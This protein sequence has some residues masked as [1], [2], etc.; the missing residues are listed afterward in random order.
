MATATA[1]PSTVRKNSYAK[2]RRLRAEG[3]TFREL[4]EK[5]NTTVWQIRKIVSA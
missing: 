2:I 5:Y 4:S 3:M 1:T